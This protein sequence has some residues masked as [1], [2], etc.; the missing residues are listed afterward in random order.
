V[1]ERDRLRTAVD[2]E[3][4]ENPLDVRSDR[5]RADDEVLRDLRLPEPVCEQPKDLGLASRKRAGSLFVHGERGRRSHVPPDARE[6]LVR[7][8]RLDHVVGADQ[9]AGG[10]VERIGP[11]AGEEEDGQPGSERVL[12]LPTDLVAADPRQLHVEDD[13]ARPLRARGGERL[14]ARPRVD[15]VVGAPR[16]L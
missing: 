10:A 9:E 3:L 4:R 16:P 15:R 14:L 2:I 6:E 5:L 8:E 13:E 12:E 11:L 1:R 7:G